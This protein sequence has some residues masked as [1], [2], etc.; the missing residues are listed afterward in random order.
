MASASIT[1]E[2]LDRITATVGVTRNLGDYNSVRLDFQVET[3]IAKDES[4]EDAASR[5]WVKAEKQ[6]EDKLAE[7]ETE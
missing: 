6:V 3:A 1:V 4:F 2:Q 5:A 7:Y